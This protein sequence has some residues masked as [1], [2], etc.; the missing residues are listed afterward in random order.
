M[1]LLQRFEWTAILMLTAPSANQQNIL[2]GRDRRA[3]RTIPSLFQLPVEMP[4]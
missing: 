2:V 4:L 3:R 1:H